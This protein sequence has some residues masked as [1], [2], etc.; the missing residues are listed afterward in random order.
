MRK[1]LRVLLLVSLFTAVLCI[2]AAAAEGPTNSGIYN[3]MKGENVTIAPKLASSTTETISPTAPASGFDE[4]YAEAEKFN[5]TYTDAAIE[6]G[7]QYLLLVC[8]G[9]GAPSESNIVY[10]NQ[11]TSVAGS[12]TFENAYPS[13]LTKGTYRIYVIGTHSSYELNSP[14]ATFEYYVPYILGDCD[15]IAGIDVRDALAVLSHIVGKR[16]LTG[17]DYLAADV[18]APKNTIDI[19]D[20][21]RILA[22]VVGKISSFND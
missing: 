15:G 6:A 4:F 21:L 19:S 17:S 8:S 12:V 7:E 14:T 2:G 20:A 13:S 16:V 18:A 5:V 1:L 9:S 10:I 11:V 22:R 3:I